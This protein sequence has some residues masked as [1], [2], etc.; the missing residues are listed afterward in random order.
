MVVVYVQE[1]KFVLKIKHNWTYRMLDVQQEQ[2]LH[3]NP[4][5]TEPYVSYAMMQH[6]EMERSRYLIR[7]F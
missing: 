6:R 3:Y 1:N 4:L 5:Q 7:P 2:H